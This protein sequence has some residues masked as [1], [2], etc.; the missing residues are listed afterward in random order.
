MPTAPAAKASRPAVV[1]SEPS[2]PLELS[3]GL[4]ELSP[5]ERR[6]AFMA[7]TAGPK[8]ETQ[9]EEPTEEQEALDPEVE[10]DPETDK[11]EAADPNAAKEPEGETSE[12]DLVSGLAKHAEKNPELK[13]LL[14]RTD[15]VLKQNS[16]RGKQLQALEA[17]LAAQRSKPAAVL[18]PSADHPLAH[19]VT[20]EQ[21]DAEVKA[22]TTD[23]RNRIRWLERHLDTGGTWGEGEHAQE[24]TPKEVQNALNYYE[25][26]RDGVAALATQRKAELAEYAATLKTLE[27]PAEDLVKPVVPTR[28]SQLFAKVPELMRDPKYLLFLAD[29]KAGRELREEKARGVKTVKVD[30]GKVKPKAEE[31]PQVDAQRAAPST[32]TDLG[33]LRSQAASGNSE[34]RAAMRRAFV[35]QIA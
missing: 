29:A 13:A 21:V 19:T 14:K 27:V 26:R 7:A 35:Q 12:D 1:K 8:A 6:A 10:T 9:K 5:A 30:P 16:E 18:A 15:K 25:D 3:P 33:Q 28:E 23:A 20:E 4:A 2:K 17:E 34:A 11:D 32:P 24:L 22:I 31:T